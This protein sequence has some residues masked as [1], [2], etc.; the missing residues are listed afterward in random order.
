MVRRVVACAALLHPLYLIG[1]NLRKETWILDR[2]QPG[3]A[4]V[5]CKLL[6]NYC[7]LTYCN[8]PYV[9]F[10]YPIHVQVQDA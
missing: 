3:T 10:L 4:F 9:V 2:C 7:T 6:L 8:Y 1:P 5:T